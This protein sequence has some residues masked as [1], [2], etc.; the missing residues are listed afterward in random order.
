M[1]KEKIF[2]KK[3][4]KV[5]SIFLT[6]NDHRLWLAAASVAGVSRSELLRLALREKSAQI[7][8]QPKLEGEQIVNL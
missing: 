4:M 3:P 7:L 8:S 1:K 2:T 5:T 6:E